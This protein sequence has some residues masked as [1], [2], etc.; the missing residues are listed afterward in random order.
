MRTVGPTL[1]YK[2]QSSATITI[3]NFQGICQHV[4][5]YA[6]TYKLFTHKLNRHLD[7]EHVNI[8][9]RFSSPTNLV[10]LTLKFGDVNL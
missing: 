10:S 8:N 1:R 5:F 9:V 4:M 2:T 7:L 3:E 6:Y